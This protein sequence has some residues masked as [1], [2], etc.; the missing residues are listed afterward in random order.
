MTDCFGDSCENG[1]PDPVH[2][3]RFSAHFPEGS[4]RTVVRVFD[5]KQGPKRIR[6]KSRIVGHEFFGV[7]RIF[8]RLSGKNGS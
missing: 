2:F 8:W 4:D 7:T 1:T 5:A 3:G 6:K